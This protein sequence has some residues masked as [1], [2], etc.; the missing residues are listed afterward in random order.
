M[1][2]LVIYDSVFGNTK[3][4]AQSIVDGLGEGSTLMH[5]SDVKPGDLKVD[6]LVVGSP[7][8][9]FNAMP[10]LNAFVAA[11]PANSLKSVRVAS[12]DTR[13]DVEVVKSKVLTT[14]VKFFGY[15]GEKILKKLASKGG[16]SV[17][18][19]AFYVLDKEGPLKDGEILRAQE[20]A[21]QLN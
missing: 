11:L 17:G 10:T 6:L 18:T 20:W 12:F 2:S 15:A 7:T 16:I 21:K 1:K 3:K 19:N 4:I 8:R 9:A 14:M 13:V 5:V